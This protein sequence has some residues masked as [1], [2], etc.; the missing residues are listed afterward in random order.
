MVAVGGALACGGDGEEGVGEHRQGGPAVPGGPGA[1]LV[2]VQA[3][4]SFAG[5]DVLL[6]PPAGSATRASVASGT[7]VVAWQRK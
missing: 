7:V 6:D 4:A 3:G 5:L 1:D 2:F